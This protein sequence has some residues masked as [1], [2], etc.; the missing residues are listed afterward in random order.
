MNDGLHK[1]LEA[2]S[3]RSWFFTPEERRHVSAFGRVF[4]LAVVFSGVGFLLALGFMQVV[5]P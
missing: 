4:V 3:Y 1:Q 2:N 5:H